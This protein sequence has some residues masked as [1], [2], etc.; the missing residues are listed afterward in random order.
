MLLTFFKH[1]QQQ[2]LTARLFGMNRSTFERLIVGFLNTDS[3]RMY[4]LCLQRTKEVWKMFNCIR[5]RRLF[6]HFGYAH[7][8]TEVT[9]RQG[10]T[11]SENVAEREEY[12][13]V[14]HSL[15][16]TKQK[17]PLYHQDLLLAARCI[18]S[19]VLLTWKYFIRIQGFITRHQRSTFG[20]STVKIMALSKTMMI[21]SGPSL[22][23][24]S[25][26]V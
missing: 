6:C 22:R 18:V 19:N 7:Q 10:C 1:G 17:L 9:L 23:L 2:N 8:V 4:E 12:F 15:Y 20:S 11:P 3:E 16:G 21:N 14:K 26:K 25:I 24:R 5:D 13:S